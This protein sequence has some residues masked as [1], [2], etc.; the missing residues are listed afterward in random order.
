MTP[1]EHNLNRTI[2]L[3][4]ISPYRPHLSNKWKK[5][6]WKGLW[7]VQRPQP[8]KRKRPR[9][10]KRERIYYNQFSSPAFPVAWIIWAA[11][12]VFLGK[13]WVPKSN[14]SADTSFWFLKTHPALRHCWSGTIFHPPTLFIPATV[15]GLAATWRL[16]PSLPRIPHGKE[17]QSWGGEVISPL[18]L[19]AAKGTFCLQTTSKAIWSRNRHNN[20]SRIWRKRMKRAVPVLPAT[21]VKYY[22]LKK[23]GDF[24]LYFVKCEERGINTSNTPVPLY[25][26]KDLSD[27]LTFS[28]RWMSR[29][30]SPIR[31]S[32]S[33]KLVSVSL[34]FLLASSMA[35]SKRF[36]SNFQEKNTWDHILPTGD[37]KTAWLLTPGCSPPSPNCLQQQ[38]ATHSWSS[39]NPC[40]HS[41]WQDS[42]P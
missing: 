24:N 2:L 6:H 21:D 29:S 9:K 38:E 17:E 12:L 27:V 4:P 5:Q 8:R 11:G 34:I 41:S 20:L 18:C 25:L 10:K 37:S 36:V 23:F 7:G 39:T 35:I 32:F 22:G 31:W 15:G 40:P 33:C 16:G 42:K 28:M 19:P 14:K 26:E 3:Q 1:I 13:L 30:S